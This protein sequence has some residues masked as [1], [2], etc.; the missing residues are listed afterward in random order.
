MSKAKSDGMSLAEAFSETKKWGQLIRALSKIDEV[1]EAAQ[2]EV[3]L[4]DE[5]KRVL[6]G[7]QGEVDEATVQLSVAKSKLTQAT[8]D[9]KAALAGAEIQAKALIEVATE[10]AYQVRAQARADVDAAQIEADEARAKTTDARRKLTVALKE[11][12]AAQDATEKLK[13]T[14]RAIAS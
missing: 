12:A 4:A 7:L 9:A 1:V 10:Q 8:A 6:A 3:A 2:S 13:A 11:L 5:R 14:A